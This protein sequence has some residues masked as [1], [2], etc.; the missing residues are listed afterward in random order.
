M[1]T[2]R[3][4]TVSALTGFLLLT[5]LL[6]SAVDECTTPRCVEDCIVSIPAKNFTSDESIGKWDPKN[7]PYTKAELDS[8]YSHQYWAIDEQWELRANVPNNC[9]GGG[10]ATFGFNGNGGY[11]KFDVNESL[12]NVYVKDRVAYVGSDSDIDLRIY[13]GA[14]A[15]YQFQDVSFTSTACRDEPS[16]ERYDCGSNVPDGDGGLMVAGTKCA[17]VALGRTNSSDE[18]Y[19]DFEVPSVG[20]PT[21]ST[22]LAETTTTTQAETTTTELSTAGTRVYEYF[23]A[24]W[25]RTVD[26]AYVEW[27]RHENVATLENCQTLC[28]EKE[29][30]AG[31]GFARTDQGFNGGTNRCKLYSCDQAAQFS[32]VTTYG[33]VECYIRQSV[34]GSCHTSC[35][36][37]VPSTST[38]TTEEPTTSTTLPETTTIDRGSC[39]DYTCP[40]STSYNG[41]HRVHITPTTDENGTYPQ[42]A[43]ADCSEEECCEVRSVMPT[44][45]AFSANTCTDTFGSL[46]CKVTSSDYVVCP[47]G[48]CDA[49]DC[50]FE[51]M[52]SVGEMVPL[53]VV[54]N[55][56]RSV[57]DRRCAIREIDLGF[58]Y[59]MEMCERAAQYQ[60]NCLGSFAYSETLGGE[61]ECCANDGSN[62]SGIGGGG[63]VPNS[64][65]TFF[66]YER[67]QFCD[68]STP[69][70][71]ASVG[72]CTS[73][74]AVGETCEPA[75]D[76]GFELTAQ[77]KCVA[78]SSPFPRLVPGRCFQSFDYVESAEVA[79]STT[80]ATIDGTVGLDGSGGAA[81]LQFSLFDFCTRDGGDFDAESCAYTSQRIDLNVLVSNYTESS[82]GEN[83]SN[84]VTLS[85]ETV[86]SVDPDSVADP[87]AFWASMSGA[88]RRRLDDIVG[89]P[90]K[91][92]EAIPNGTIAIDLSDL[93]QD[94]ISRSQDGRIAL[95]I[96]AV[97][98]SGG[99]YF[100][101]AASSSGDDPHVPSVSIAT[102]GD[103]QEINDCVRML[104]N[105]SGCADLETCDDADHCAWDGTSCVLA[106]TESS[107][108]ELCLR[109]DDCKI[110]DCSVFDIAGVGLAGPP[111][112]FLN[113][114]SVKE[115]VTTLKL[116]DNALQSLSASTFE[117]FSSL[118]K[119]HLERTG[120]GLLESGSFRHLSSLAELYLS[121]CT[122]GN[123]SWCNSH[124]RFDSLATQTFSNLTALLVLD[125][126]SNEIESTPHGLFDPLESLE[127]LH[128]T[129]NTL[130]SSSISEGRY[131]RSMPRL[132]ELHL[133]GNHIEALS[134]SNLRGLTTLELLDLNHNQIQTIDE[135]AF[136]DLTGLKTLWLDGNG[137]EHL[138]KNL[139][140]GLANLTDLYLYNNAFT[141]MPKLGSGLSSLR[142]LNVFNNFLRDIQRDAFSG[143]A[144]DRLDLSNQDIVHVRDGAFSGSSVCEIKLSGNNVQSVSA[145]AFEN[146]TVG[147]HCDGFSSACAD[148]ENWALPA[149]AEDR[150]GVSNDGVGDLT[151]ANIRGMD[152]GTQGRFVGREGS[153]GFSP[154]D[155]CCSIGGGG[156]TN[157]QNLLFDTNSAVSCRIDSGNAAGFTVRCRCSDSNL[158]YSS[159][160]YG[161][162]VACSIG[163][164]WVP[165]T[166]SERDR[167]GVDVD[168][169]MG[170]C[171]ACPAGSFGNRSVSSWP[172]TCLACSAGTYADE[173]A[174]ASCRP[175][176][177]HFFSSAIGA[178]ACQECPSGRKSNADN[179]ACDVCEW[180]YYGSEHCETPVFGFALTVAVISSL[181][182]V[183]A[184]LWVAYYHYRKKKRRFKIGYEK[185]KELLKT[186][187]DDATLMSAAWHFDWSEV[188]TVEEM[189]HGASGRIF[190]GI[191]H[192][193]W[194]VAVKIMTG[195]GNAADE[196]D[197]AEIRFLQRA[198][199]PRLVMFLGMGKT[200]DGDLFVVLEYMEVGSYDRILWLR[201]KKAQGKVGQE[202]PS[203]GQRVQILTDVAEG[204]AFI[205]SVLGSI[206]RDLK[207]MNILL[208][209]D[210]SHGCECKYRAKIA[211]FGM[212]RLLS[213][214]MLASA[215]KKAK[216]L[217]APTLQP[218]DFE[219]DYDEDEED[220]SGNAYG[221]EFDTTGSAES[222][223]YSGASSVYASMTSVLGTPAYMAPELVRAV[224][225]A[226]ILS[227]YSQAVDMYA[228]GCIMWESIYLCPPWDGLASTTIYKRVSSGKRP[229]LSSMSL[230]S[231][232]PE[233][234][235][236]LMKSA[237]TDDP[238]SRP[239]FYPTFQRLQDMRV[240]MR[241]L[242]KED[243]T[244]T[245]TIA[246]ATKI[247]SDNAT[248]ADASGGGDKVCVVGATVEMTAISDPMSHELI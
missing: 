187:Y 11:L 82:I 211:D 244:P 12:T 133:G 231:G 217:R 162:V 156:F 139:F 118:R 97:N 105:S 246:S 115:T 50:C 90:P 228:F 243:M 18:D 205:H 35:L 55:V 176:D 146:W 215:S 52:S 91:T 112:D 72:S 143:L 174:S 36:Q 109:A 226:S 219:N 76:A 101:N 116:S 32:G 37:C 8:L 223:L 78:N 172:E 23:G 179:T 14:D 198:R 157:G 106:S 213:D 102:S 238:D 128:L 39:G 230:L 28:D 240:A 161:C 114:I 120:L 53:S 70:S 87:C 184:L 241:A 100:S 192:R 119:L 21:T 15:T 30:C 98:M 108:L 79:C 66:S 34:S 13:C 24:G 218:D 216:S 17:G 200:G 214:E 123:V 19:W 235:V 84:P 125:M 155:A 242:R 54:T 6:V 80:N 171:R 9:S 29:E 220:D 47:S 51:C 221:D 95:E 227:T 65:F 204:M 58:F 122:H 45:G 185:S 135:S 178:S 132:K 130:T 245:T 99:L 1:T 229:P 180:S 170:A 129:N 103:A 224:K 89:S 22:T 74:L 86:E 190:R 63:S 88:R 160:T 16:S 124:N 75:C 183:W 148:Y 186:A 168:V 3:G 182:V 165:G 152:Y 104:Q 147:S 126:T 20:Q 140:A 154:M 144:V 149:V 166:A 167:L 248:F 201:R 173:T 85:F 191:L 203:W 113:S 10:T 121:G 67:T 207:S 107:S 41:T 57:Q 212:A 137:I 92:V 68:A 81:Y 189:A 209:T 77:T 142:T 33:G 136:A 163:E 96:S 236:E 145:L 197:D 239:S 151:C 164:Y 26:N 199:H 127:A 153:A 225:G 131:G 210:E 94:E 169:K 195:G 42:C 25:C 38:T 222:G 40:L 175:C 31:I 27:I 4:A 159:D 48:E 247:T 158:A 2:T 69:P 64:N 194:V 110:R 208:T 62:S 196:K 43:G 73:S 237:W 5:N 188:E 60:P 234:Y 134:N 181:L 202:V 46:F 141:E 83:R 44:C 59:T 93:L 61:C 193:K 117:C 111:G 232:A 206:H 233:G 49:S 138:P 150:V 177:D 7:E 56:V 71:N